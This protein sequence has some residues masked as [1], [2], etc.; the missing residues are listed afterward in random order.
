[1]KTTILFWQWISFRYPS[2]WPYS[3]SGWKLR[4]SRALGQDSFHQ[5][6][7]GRK[8]QLEHSVPEIP[9]PL[10]RNHVSYGYPVLFVAGIAMWSKVLDYHIIPVGASWFVALVLRHDAGGDMARQFGLE[11]FFYFSIQSLTGW[12]TPDALQRV[13]FKKDFAW[14]K[15]WLP[16]LFG[17]NIPDTGYF[18]RSRH[19]YCFTSGNAGLCSEIQRPQLIRWSWKSDRRVFFYIILLCYNRSHNDLDYNPDF[20]RRKR[21]KKDTRIFEKFPC[22]TSWIIVSDGGSTDKTVEIAKSYADKW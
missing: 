22:N 1:L 13:I 20:T 5:S 18:P 9:L 19:S 14:F 15:D 16:P 17:I 10:S 7:L 8:A 4:T 21:H 3:K 12:R 2:F 11:D 6:L